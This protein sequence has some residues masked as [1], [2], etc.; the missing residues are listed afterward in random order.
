MTGTILSVSPQALR[1]YLGTWDGFGDWHT[2]QQAAHAALTD[3]RPLWKRI[4]DRILSF[5]R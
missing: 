4:R 1:R 5:R 2:A 3:P